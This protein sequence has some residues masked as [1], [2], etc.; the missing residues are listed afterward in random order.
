MLMGNKP[1]ENLLCLGTVVVHRNGVEQAP[2]TTRERFQDAREPAIGLCTKP[3]QCA[4]A[5][6]VQHRQSVGVRVL[7]IVCAIGTSMP[8][9]GAGNDTLCWRSAAGCAMA[10]AGQ[11]RELVGDKCQL[12]CDTQRCHQVCHTGEANRAEVLSCRSCYGNWA[13]GPSRAPRTTSGVPH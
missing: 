9:L 3:L 13:A 7:E 11:R 1:S 4:E 2:A 6:T 8:R 12:V 10:H 5:V